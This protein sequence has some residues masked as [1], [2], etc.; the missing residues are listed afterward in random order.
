MSGK[1][2]HDNGARFLIRGVTYGTFAPGDDGSQFPS[3]DRVGPDF[4]A[5]AEL[6]AN[7]IRTYTC[8]PTAVLDEAAR[9]GLRVIVGVPWSQ[10]VAFLED[11]RIV[12][13]VRNTV[14][15][16]VKRLASHPATLLFTIGNE[17]PAGIVRWHGRKRIER[18]MREL[19]EETK[20]AAPDAIVTYVNY[21]PT[22]YLDL[23]FFDVCA[24]NIF[25]HAQTDFAA[26]LAR[27][28]H[29]A[30]PRPLLIA[31][32]GA[33]SLRHG[34][35]RQAALV[36]MQAR[37]AFR[38]GAAG[39]VVFSWTDEWWRGGRPVD[40]WAF[41]LVDTRRQRKPAYDAVRDVFG[42]APFQSAEQQTWPRV[43]VVVCAYNEA[44]T[45]HECLTA[46]EELRY[47]DFECIVVND[48]STDETGS[49][50][51]QHPRVRLIETANEGLSAA[52]NLG[53]ER[54]TGDIV[55]Y[56]DAD[57]RVDPDWL[58]YLV[59][60]F[61][62]SDVVA[63][64]GP[65]VVPPDDAW[66]AQCVARAPGS[67]MHVLLDDRLAEH[68]PGCNCA[69]RRAALMAI[70]GFNP[71]FRRAGD[72]V[73][74]CWRLQAQ[75]GKIGF[76]PAALVWHHHR[77]TV[78]AFLRQQVG[79][80]EGEAWLMHEHPHKFIGGRI[81]W[82]GH[83]YS[84][85]PFIRSLSETRI[86]AGPFG[87][88]AFPSI[89]RTDPHPFA[90]MAHSGRWQIGWAFCIALAAVAALA[91][92]SYAYPLLAVGL[93][94][95]ATTTGKCLQYGLQADLPSIGRPPG[96]PSA[97]VYRLTIAL[98]HFL[99]PF[100]RLYGRVRGAIWRPT[101]DQRRR[102]PRSPVASVT[103][104][105]GLRLASGRELEQRF[106]SERWLDIHH[107][108]STIAERLRHHR[109]IRHIEV[110]SGWWE[111]RDVIIVNRLG[112]LLDMRAVVEDHGGG[113]SLCR[114]RVRLRHGVAI[115]PL[116]LAVTT[117][118]LLDTANLV[119]WPISTT[120]AVLLTG[121]AT[122][123]ET[124][125]TWRIVSTALHD[126]TREFGMFAMETASPASAREPASIDQ[127]EMT[128]AGPWP[129]S[130][131]VA[132]EPNRHIA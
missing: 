21:P 93:L 35:D 94:A 10:H 7:T 76:A 62:H 19:F 51:A 80:G 98:L 53:L 120:V 2:L 40:D 125:T 102:S 15:D 23:S 96:E 60:P 75:G 13:D 118:M 12:R 25:L 100:A 48:G 24:F 52:R 31:E 103:L 119:P 109:A 106:W 108:L 18:F 6:G 30:G 58:T 49:I 56:T 127:P 69:F 124:M 47:P 91:H 42:S 89:Y 97:A 43:T 64:G 121:A 130:T 22:E 110:D 33:D 99:Q 131:G 81:A 129:E 92:Q 57:A 41:G 82:A 112:H 11:A 28:Q 39:V 1:F 126:V 72:D 85:L 36:A 101:F 65:N 107:V 27:L 77:N 5:I 32:A 111:A 116:L 79:Y 54:A 86:H 74:V 128:V 46:I 17:I 104:A 132:H 122:V 105:D 3:L 50:A 29:L 59:Q 83:I 37:T 90:Y 84:S 123:A 78:S 38:E 55:A 115:V 26:Y 63:A 44:R 34:T 95:L 71:I 20:A 70:G 87:S 45:I 66:L 8:P 88:K 117:V 68:V 9:R 114:L 113:R 61:V 4:A 67:P 73:D 14:R 16:A